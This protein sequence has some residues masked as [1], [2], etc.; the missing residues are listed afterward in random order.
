MHQTTRQ[1]VAA[2]RV[3]QL[4]GERRA[5]RPDGMAVR[6]SAAFHIDNVLRQ[7]KLTCHDDG[8]G[9]EGFVDLR[10]L[11]GANVPA[12]ALQRLLDRRHRSQ[13]EHARL[14]R[15]DAVRDEARCRSKTTLVG[16]RAVGEHHGGSSIVQSRGV[17][18][19]NC[20]IWTERRLEP[21]Q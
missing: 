7:A 21:R 10:T 16:P 1:P 3:D 8:D 5:R 18:G 6:D 13:S 2:H 4:G 17:A 14:D 20:A 9:C 11:D 19:R 12:G 15:R